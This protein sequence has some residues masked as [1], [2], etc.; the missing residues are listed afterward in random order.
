[1][2]AEATCLEAL[3]ES[4]PSARELLAD[5]VLCWGKVRYVKFVQRAESFKSAKTKCLAYFKERTPEQEQ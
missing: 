5:P 4:S 2:A 1:L 3:D